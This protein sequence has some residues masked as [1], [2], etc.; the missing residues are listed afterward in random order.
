MPQK[1]AQ[2]T[3][4]FQVA[5]SKHGSSIVKSIEISFLERECSSRFFMT[6]SMTSVT[7]HMTVCQY[8]INLQD[9]MILTGGFQYAQIHE[10]AEADLGAIGW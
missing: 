5:F 2:V 10:M 8:M 1:T 9:A 4:R 3:L 7:Y 6:A